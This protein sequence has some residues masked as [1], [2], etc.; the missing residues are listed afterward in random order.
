[1][2]FSAEITGKPFPTHTDTQKSHF[3]LGVP[4]RN[5]VDLLCFRE[6]LSGHVIA[7]PLCA[8]NLG[9]HKCRL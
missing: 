6:R 1:M 4:S 3:F 9:D 2:F 5:F 7:C 8:T